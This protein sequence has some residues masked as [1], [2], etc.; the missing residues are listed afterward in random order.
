MHTWS[1]K[2]VNYM[3]AIESYDQSRSHIAVEFCYDWSTSAIKA[4]HACL[5]I[6]CA[7]IYLRPGALRMFS[8][9]CWR[10]VAAPVKLRTPRR[11]PCWACRASSGWRTRTTWVTSCNFPLEGIFPIWRRLKSKVW[12]FFKLCSFQPFSFAKQMMPKPFLGNVCFW[13][14]R[15]RGGPSDVFSRH[16]VAWPRSRTENA[17]WWVDYVWS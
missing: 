7:S 16:R 17:Y 15:E 4:C 9:C 11:T 14:I 10:A 6:I 3:F 2:S 5:F 13:R 12:R 1:T 8:I